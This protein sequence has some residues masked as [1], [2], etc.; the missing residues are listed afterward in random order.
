[1]SLIN[2]FAVLIKDVCSDCEY[3]S[4]SNVIYIVYRYIRGE[5]GVIFEVGCRVEIVFI[6][7]HV[8]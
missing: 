7:G 3:A 8:I 6:Q 5:V 1:M 2:R 4:G